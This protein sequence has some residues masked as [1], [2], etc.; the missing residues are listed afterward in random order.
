MSPALSVGEFLGITRRFTGVHAND[1][2]NLTLHNGRAL[3][4]TTKCTA[5]N[6]SSFSL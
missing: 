2:I 6:R 4:I 1:N 5:L 3:G